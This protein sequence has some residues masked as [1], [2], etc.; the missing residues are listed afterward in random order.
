MDINTNDKFLLC[1]NQIPENIIQL[2]DSTSLKNQQK[3]IQNL[4][5]KELI[6]SQYDMNLKNRDSNPNNN[7]YNNQNKNFNNNLNNNCPN[8]QHFQINSNS[9]NNKISFCESE[10]YFN[11]IKNNYNFQENK[12]NEKLNEIVKTIKEN[13]IKIENMNK[14]MREI[15][16]NSSNELN[17]TRNFINQSN[18]FEKIQ[19]ENNILKTDALIYREDIANLIEQNK[20]LAEDLET[21]RKKILQLISKNND[22]VKEIN[23]RDFQISK[24]N[25][26][27]VRLRFY[28]NSDLEYNKSKEQVLNE[29]EL[30][31]KALSEEKNILN[32]EKKILEKKIKELINFKEDLDHNISYKN[33]ENEKDIREM[34]TKVMILENEIRNLNLENNSLNISTAK[35]EK[36]VENLLIEKNNLE[37]QYLNK[38]EEFIKLQNDYNN[39]NDK[40]QQLLIENK[41]EIEYQEK[42][43]SMSQKKIKREKNIDAINLLF[44]QIQVFK[45]Q[46]RRE[47]QNDH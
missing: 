39:L 40:Y 15:I 26:A 12:Y 35:S 4:S 11:L 41:N 16:I 45:S 34:K 18:E 29:A 44:N 33:N 10:P 8:I 14:T 13:E 30:E 21:S 46:V 47:R 2:N 9:F 6:Y 31:Y 3:I 5:Q 20:K 36:E 23:Q 22:I 38:N 37:N 24:L 7:F 19:Q 32:N 1:N 25:D 17:N 28:K 42:K 27:I 43:R